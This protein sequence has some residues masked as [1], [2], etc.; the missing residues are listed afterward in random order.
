MPIEPVEPMIESFFMLRAMSVVYVE[1]SFRDEE[2]QRAL[3]LV[4]A[5]HKVFMKGQNDFFLPHRR[6]N[7]EQDVFIAVVHSGNL[8][9]DV[10]GFVL[11]R[12]SFERLP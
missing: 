5:S 12:I 2:L 1:Q 6:R 11:Y 9:D 7:I 3:F 8:A 10:A 4:K